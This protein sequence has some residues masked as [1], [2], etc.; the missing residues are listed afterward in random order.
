MSAE[1][2]V[3]NFYNAMPDTIS[4][5]WKQIDDTKNIIIYSPV[6]DRPEEVEKIGSLPYEPL[7]GKKTS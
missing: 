4:F 1:N 3:K 7:F 5:E 2:T 6:E